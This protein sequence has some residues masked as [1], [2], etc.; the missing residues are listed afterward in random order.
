MPNFEF[1]TRQKPWTSLPI[2]YS[3]F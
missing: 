3:Y 1:D 2:V